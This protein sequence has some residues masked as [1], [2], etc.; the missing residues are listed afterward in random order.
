METNWKIIA[1]IAIVGLV[2]VAVV[3]N[4]RNVTPATPLAE[5]QPAV[6]TPSNETQVIPP[7]PHVSGNID[8]MMSVLANEASGDA[9]LVSSVADMAAVVK[10]DA[11]EVNSLTTAY[12][13]TT[14]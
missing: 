4:L 5:E 2:L 13:E 1:P 3:M 6:V 11:Q 14:F 8:D 12:D 10:S 7:A 9:A